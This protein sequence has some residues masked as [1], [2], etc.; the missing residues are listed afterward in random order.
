[1]AKRKKKKTV[2]VEQRQKECGNHE[3]STPGQHRGSA[4][5]GKRRAKKTPQK[6]T[7]PHPQK[8]NERTE[9]EREGEGLPRNNT[10]QRSLLES[11]MGYNAANSSQSPCATSKEKSEKRGTWEKPALDRKKKKKTERVGSSTTLVQQGNS[12]KI[13]DREEGR[14]R[15]R[16]AREHSHHRHIE[17]KLGKSHVWKKR[18]FIYTSHTIRGNP[19]R[20]KI[21]R[22]T[23][24]TVEKK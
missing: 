20:K 5:E 17:E 22:K 7:N 14:S 19:G 18:G 8:K 3:K 1:V 15:R 2:D 12:A 16:R 13:G 24:T 10:A 11:R 6:K 21:S 23:L 9:R 4:W